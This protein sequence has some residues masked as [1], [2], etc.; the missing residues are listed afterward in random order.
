M[1]L[2]V[3]P[4]FNARMVSN[5]RIQDPIIVNPTAPM[6]INL[7]IFSS[8]DVTEESRTSMMRLD[9]LDPLF[10]AQKWTQFFDE[11]REIVILAQSSGQRHKL[12]VPAWCFERRCANIQTRLKLFSF[13]SGPT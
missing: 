6:P 5:A 2:L 10:A 8:P 9:H 12:E 7:P 13:A 1:K 11:R 3:W 4:D